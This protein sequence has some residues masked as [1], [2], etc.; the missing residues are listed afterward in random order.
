MVSLHLLHGNGLQD[1]FATF[2]AKIRRDAKASGVSEETVSA[3]LD[4][5]VMPTTSS[6]SVVRERTS[7]ERIETWR[8]YLARRASEER[9]EAAMAALQSFEPEATAIAEHFG[10]PLSVLGALWSVESSCGRFCGS[11]DAMK[12]LAA[13]AF[14]PGSDPMRASYFQ[15]EMVAAMKLLERVGGPDKRTARSVWLRGSYAGALGQCQFM[16]SNVLEC[17]V[18]WDGDGTAD[19]WT[20]ELDALASMA[21]FLI[22]RGWDPQQNWSAAYP[23]TSANNK[24][25]QAGAKT[26]SMLN[27]KIRGAIDVCSEELGGVW[28]EP[29]DDASLRLVGPPEDVQFLV[30]SNFDVLM[31]YNP[32]PKYAAAVSVLSNKIRRRLESNADRR[33]AS[34]EAVLNAS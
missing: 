19:V 33:P 29:P 15:R 12:S 31:R 23:V 27:W 11:H 18:D 8:E 17:A 13:L 6:E 28:P 32:S 3:C 2:L 21:Q 34:H 25:V 5:L 30:G 22:K 14:V 16:P 1:E 26:D 4:D 9:A 24:Q 7:A 10:V 20:S